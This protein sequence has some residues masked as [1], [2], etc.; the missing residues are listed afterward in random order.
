MTFFLVKIGSNRQH[1]DTVS[2]Q[3]AAA[4]TSYRIVTLKQ[5]NKETMKTTRK[6]MIKNE[7]EED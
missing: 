1:W 2:S 4:S 7:D 3:Y 5:S 6:K